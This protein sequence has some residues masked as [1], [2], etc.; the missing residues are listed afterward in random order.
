M[1]KIRI[2]D[3][4]K[5]WL[6]IYCVANLFLIQ[7]LESH[8]TW[9]R[10]LKLSVFGSGNF[11]ICRTPRECVSWNS[12]TPCT[13]TQ[14]FCRT[15]RECVSW[16]EQLSFDDVFR[17]VALHVSAW[18]EM[19]DLLDLGTTAQSHSTWV[20]ELKFSSTDHGQGFPPVAL[21]VSA[22]VEMFG[23][24]SKL[25]WIDVALHVSAWVEI[26]HFIGIFV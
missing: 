5:Q 16:N 23:S 21:H 2:I 17:R 6:P 18:V 1:K 26:L 7:Y 4:K 13:I 24:R 19:I 25:F 20:R 3:D 11:Q 9:V 22:W 14:A 15:P 12:E 10:E 8:S